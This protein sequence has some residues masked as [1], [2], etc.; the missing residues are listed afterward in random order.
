VE[1][2]CKAEADIT[3]ILG[4]SNKAVR[5]YKDKQKLPD[6]VLQRFYLEHT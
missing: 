2:D 5:C 4:H 1:Y 6:K 3:C